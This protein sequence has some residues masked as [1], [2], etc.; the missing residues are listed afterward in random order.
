MAAR[1]TIVSVLR[2]VVFFVSVTCYVSI[3]ELLAVDDD[4]RI[5]LGC[6]AVSAGLLWYS[7]MPRAL[8]VIVPV[9]GAIVAARLLFRRLRDSVVSAVLKM[10]ADS[11]RYA[12]NQA[13]RNRLQQAFDAQ[14]SALDLQAG[15]RVIV[16]AHS[17][18]SIITIDSLRR[19]DSPLRNTG[20]IELVTAG[21]PLRRIFARFFP[22]RYPS[23]C[24]IAAELVGDG[25]IGAWVN[26]YRPF[27]P[28]GASIGREQC[29]SI[30]DVSTEQG[31][32]QP[33]SAGWA[34][35]NYWSDTLVGQIVQKKLGQMS[36]APHRAT[37]PRPGSTAGRLDTSATFAKKRAVRLFPSRRRVTEVPKP[38]G[39]GIIAAVLILLMWYLGVPA[40]AARVM[41]IRQRFADTKRH[42]AL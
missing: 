4:L 34:H 7:E 35:V 16:G 5:L 33:W 12:G 21:S 3:K 42:S 10:L 13:Y 38:I 2:P 36:R 14:I 25:V 6:A 29:S 26:V 9:L 20:G 39:I 41:E 8:P 17:L 11:V 18:G 27:D 1:W 19:P 37:V 15:A 30:V 28:V 23:A 24:D 31:A 32:K 22:A 40:H